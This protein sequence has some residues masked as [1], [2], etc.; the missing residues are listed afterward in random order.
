MSEEEIQQEEVTEETEV[1][2]TNES[3]ELDGEQADEQEEAATSDGDDSTAEPK[4]KG[5][6]KR[7]DELVRQREDKAREAEYWR[8]QALQKAPEKTETPTQQT[9]KPTVE[10]FDSYETYLD[11]LSDWKVDQRLKEQ[12]EQAEQSQRAQSLE[13]KQAQFH[14]KAASFKAEDFQEVAF[15]P[16][17]PISDAMRDVILD[18][19]KGPELLYHL[20]KNSSEAARIASLSPVQ[21]ARELGLL[22]AKMSL[23]KA[24]TKSN[25]PPPIPPISGGGNPPETDPMKLTPD[26]WAMRRNQELREKGRI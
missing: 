15:N 23:P 14:Q 26:E 2:E 5:V 21:A 1:I 22:E 25:A 20:G 17:L 7:I 10:N 24:K 9:G 8:Q 6:Q 3:A 11:A 4:K 13:Q 16:T 12:R 18:S 19:D